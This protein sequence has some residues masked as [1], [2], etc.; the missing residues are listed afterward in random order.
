MGRAM[1]YRVYSG[2]MIVAVYLYTGIQRL[3]IVYRGLQVS[4]QVYRSTECL[5]KV[6]RYHTCGLKQEA[7]TQQTKSEARKS[8]PCQRRAFCS[9]AFNVF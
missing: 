5:Q 4:I 9:S 6:Y 8:K 1:V 3:Q 2:T 7:E